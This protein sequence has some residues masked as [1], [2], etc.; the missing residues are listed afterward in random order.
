MSFGTNATLQLGRYDVNLVDRLGQGGFGVVYPGRHRERNSNVAVKQCMTENNKSGSVAISEL[1]NFLFLKKHPHFVKM[2]YCDFRKN[3]VWIVMEFC[4]GGNLEQYFKRVNPPIEAQLDLMF[5]S[6]SAIEFMHG[7]RQVVVHRD[8]KPANILIKRQKGQD[9]VKVTDFGLSKVSDNPDPAKTAL[10]TT[11]A[12]TAGYMAP[13]F[14]LPDRP[15][16]TK[17]V[18][19]FSLG[20]VF[21]AMVIYKPKDHMMSPTKG[22]I[23]F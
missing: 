9:I 13:E 18:D 15:K 21:L 14:F 2:L 6:A 8:I 22:L 23:A 19:T 12:G 7:Q 16:Y 10:F 1:R 5:Q 3:A 11:K 17:A 20:L 4:E